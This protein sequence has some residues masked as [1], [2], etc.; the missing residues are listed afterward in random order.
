MAGIQAISALGGTDSNA[1]NITRR[2]AAAPCL[3]AT[4]QVV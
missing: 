4:G 3:A 2:G 1:L